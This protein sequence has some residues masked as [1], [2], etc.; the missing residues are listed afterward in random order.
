MTFPQASDSNPNDRIRSSCGGRSSESSQWGILRKEDIGL[1]KYCTPRAFS[2][3]VTAMYTTIIIMFTMRIQMGQGYRFKEEALYP[4]VR[5]ARENFIENISVVTYTYIRHYRPTTSS[6]QRAEGSR[7]TRFILLT[8]PVEFPG[9]HFADARVGAGHDRD[10]PVQPSLARALSAEHGER[11]ICRQSSSRT[12]AEPGDAYA[13]RRRPF[14]KMFFCF[15]FLPLSS[16]VWLL[17][18][19][20]VSSRGGGER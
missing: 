17:R 1:Q 3:T 13:A 18:V 14:L 8:Y 11:K 4:P 5:F 15:F 20:R 19:A 7:K 16:V 2:S 12:M 9:R 10:L 6:P